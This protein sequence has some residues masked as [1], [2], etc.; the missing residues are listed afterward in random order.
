MRVRQEAKILKNHRRE[1]TYTTHIDSDG[2]EFDYPVS[3]YKPMRVWNAIQR[4]KKACKRRYLNNARLA[5]KNGSTDLYKLNIHKAYSP[6]LMEDACEWWN[7]PI[8][9]PYE[10]EPVVIFR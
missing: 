10:L 1:L 2:E 7:I 9:S 6:S 8:N 3:R 4:L 5:K